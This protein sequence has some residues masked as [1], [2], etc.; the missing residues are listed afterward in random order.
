MWISLNSSLANTG[1][2]FLSVNR[3]I[4]T[5]SLPIRFPT[6]RSVALAPQRLGHSPLANFNNWLWDPCSGLLG[7]CDNSFLLSLSLGNFGYI[8]TSLPHKAA[9]SEKENVTNT[10]FD[11]FHYYSDPDHTFIRDR[12]YDIVE[13]PSILKF[14]GVSHWVFRLYIYFSFLPPPVSH[15]APLFSK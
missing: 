4:L 6:P 9:N 7:D 11:R 5:G 14:A 10:T 3:A 12:S 1:E 8:P 13:I 2:Y 15:L